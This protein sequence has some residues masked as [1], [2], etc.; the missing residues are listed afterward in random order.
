M[1]RDRISSELTI[2]LYALA[3]AIPLLMFTAIG[4][5]TLT[6]DLLNAKP[7]IPLWAS[8]VV[9]GCFLVGALAELA[10]F[11]FA[12]AY[13]NAGAAVLFAVL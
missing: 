13:F 6:Q 10:G 8:S 3:V 5:L 9:S 7:K 11:T 4:G 2:S 1:G 12:I